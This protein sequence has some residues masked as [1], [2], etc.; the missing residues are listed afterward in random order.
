MADATKAKE[1]AEQAVPTV[2]LT[3]DG[4]ETT[5]PKGTTVLDAARAMGITIPSFCAH[6]KLKPVGSCRM[7]YVEIEKMPKLMVSC[8]TECMDGMI[9]HTDSDLV[10]RG[11]RAV[12]EFT[13]LNH[14]LDC[15]TCDKGGEC[16]LQDLTFG[17]GFDDSR[18]DFQKYRFR[19]GDM[20]TT[21]DDRRIGPEIVL[22]RNRCIIC[23]KCVRANKEAFGEFD[24]GAYERGNITEINSAPG[25]EVSNP[26]SGNLVEICPVGALTNTDWRYKIRVWLTKTVSSV[27]PFTSS[28]SN[29]LFYKED[30]Q[31]KIFRVTSRPNDDIDDGWIADVTRYGYQIV[32]SPDRLK[33]PLIRRDGKQVEATWEEAI[34]VIR[35]RLSEIVDKAGCVCIGA[36]VA[37]WLDNATQF[38]VSKLIRTHLGSNNIDSRVDYRMLPKQSGGPYD[39]LHR[40]PFHIA[41]IDTSDVIFTF[42]TDLLKEHPN[43]YL[44]IRK[45]VNFHSASVLVADA[46]G[47]KQVDVAAVKATY[48]PGTEEAF[49]NGLCAAAIEE[50]MVDA[51]RVGNLKSLIKPDTSEEAAKICGVT[52]EDLVGF[53]RKLA[54]AKK[55]SL[56]VG[57]FV[58]RSHDREL[59][60][61]S[62]C[63]L[64]KLFDINHRGQAT[65]LARYANSRGADMLG[66]IPEPTPEIKQKLTTMFGSW[67]EAAPL[68]TD[69]MLLN[70]KKEE[71][72][73]CLVFGA[74]PVMT[75]PDREFALESLKK[76]DFLVVADSFE[77]ETTELADVVLPLATWAEFDG[78][79]VN[80]EGCPQNAFKGLKPIGESKSGAE[81]VDL[82]AESLGTPLFESGKGRDQQIDELLAEWKAP[83]MPSDYLEVAYEAEEV[84]GD[85]PIP[86]FVG[87]DPHHCGHL[88][89]KAPSLVNFCGEAYIEI[90]SE[91]AEELKLVAGDS[92]RVESP[93]GKVIVPLRISKW[94]KGDA[95]FIPRNFSS[96]HITALL[97]RKLRVDRVKITKVEK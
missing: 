70:M 54:D 71:V 26:F 46:Y 40:Q 79:Y 55:I 56:L 6:P 58:S 72:S 92:V 50:Q 85:Y 75:Y 20:T 42:G 3:I 66:A 69:R 29:I 51:S 64:I 90:S 25:E 1:Q 78:Q 9:V 52:R 17:Y 13:L 74:N 87:D 41:D 10:K 27:C 84:S 57:E 33:T 37:P 81:I 5:V 34:E 14:P 45:A 62:L 82:I 48:K 23:Y 76:L 88:T 28:G 73:G 12:I 60:A 15:P 8:S 2:T 49:I 39:I 21:F 24:L 32:N 94:M 65:I 30:H 86:L 35:D 18:F 93:G 19:E 91:L 22:N 47:T 59:I 83:S 63:N 38:S 43:E 80:L 61:A 89:E 44:R 11:R 77:T 31:H 67:P 96:T 97:S 53:A 68:T 4:R 95:A 7:C 36:L 16:T